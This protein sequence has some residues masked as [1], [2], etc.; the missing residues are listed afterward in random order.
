LHDG[1][2]WYSI[3]SSIGEDQCGIHKGL[4]PI[5]DDGTG[6]KIC[7]GVNN[8]NMGEIFFLDH[9][10]HP[11]DDPDSLEGII[12]LANSFTEFLSNFREVK[13]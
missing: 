1:P 10:I 5:G 13:H 7:I 8:N 11:Y 3:E 2:I 12:K 6:N 4:I 9:E